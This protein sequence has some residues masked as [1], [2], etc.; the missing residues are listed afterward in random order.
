MLAVAR[1]LRLIL[2]LSSRR[3]PVRCVQTGI[4]RPW[5][6]SG[7]AWGCP[8]FSHGVDSF[9][10]RFLSVP[11]GL[12]HLRSYPR[13]IERKPEIHSA[14]FGIST[15]HS[16]LSCLWKDIFASLVMEYRRSS[17]FWACGW[18]VEGLFVGP[19]PGETHSSTPS[20]LQACVSNS[21][22][23]MASLR[24]GSTIQKQREAP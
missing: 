9:G 10:T 4:G 1:I 11:V 23:I 22:H 14:T 24:M 3:F 6:A 2:I 16:H 7:Y 19:E 8:S 13:C 15:H 18:F 12:S 20:Y 17:T 5:R 21:N